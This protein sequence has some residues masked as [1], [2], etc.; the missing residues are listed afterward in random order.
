MELVEVWD[1]KKLNISGF[2]LYGCLATAQLQQIHHI[3]KNMFIRK[4]EHEVFPHPK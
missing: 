2:N 4:R 1:K 3:L